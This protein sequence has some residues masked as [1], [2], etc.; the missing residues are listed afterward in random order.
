MSDKWVLNA[1]PLILLAKVG[2]VGLFPKLT[3][4]LVIP[5]S[6]VAEIQAGPATDRAKAWL[7]GEGARW[8][9]PDPAPVAA[10]AGAW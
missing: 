7:A 6:V 3:K 2:Q 1:S 9:Q 8:V 4:R 5:A 10:I